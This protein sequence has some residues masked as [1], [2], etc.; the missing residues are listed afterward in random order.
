MVQNLS[1][2]SMRRS[3]GQI[4]GSKDSASRNHASVRTCGSKIKIIDCS[5]VKLV[6]L[7][8]VRYYRRELVLEISGS[9]SLILYCKRSVI[10]SHEWYSSLAG[11]SHHMEHRL[12][13]VA[14][15]ARP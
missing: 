15:Q 6:S 14:N 8:T 11:G 12:A 9:E 5:S 1:M 13:Y 3:F 2:K 7:P 10:L 4:Q